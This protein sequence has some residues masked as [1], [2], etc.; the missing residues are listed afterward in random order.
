MVPQQKMMV[1]RLKNDDSS[2][3][4]DDLRDSGWRARLQGIVLGGG[5]SRPW[6]LG[7][8]GQDLCASRDVGAGSHAWLHA[9]RYGGPGN[10]V[11]PPNFPAGWRLT[12]T[13]FIIFS[14]EFIISN[15]K[16][17]ILNQN[18]SFQQ[19]PF[20]TSAPDGVPTSR[21]K[22]IGFWWGQGSAWIG[23]F[24]IHEGSWEENE[25]SSLEKW[26]FWAD[27][28]TTSRS[29]RGR[30]PQARAALRKIRG[31]ISSSR[32]RTATRSCAFHPFHPLL[33]VSYCHQ[34]ARMGLFWVDHLHHYI[35]GRSS[36]YY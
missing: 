5:H 26:W 17:I 21:S 28:T 27:Q 19:M 35:I 32:P 29:N 36:Y 31:R 7:V 15:A 13:K 23:A 11:R 3:E 10:C 2:V 33:C 30:S 24:I 6:L 8:A 1:L 12:G 14:T 18:S 4:D 25:D 22:P 34:L 16:L 20:I 9:D